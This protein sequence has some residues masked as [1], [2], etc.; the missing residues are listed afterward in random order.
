M[1]TILRL[2]QPL[3]QRPTLFLDS[4]RVLRNIARMSARAAAAGVLLRPHFKTHQSVAVGDW[5]RDYG[6]TG[7][8][9]SSVSMAEYFAAADWR[10][11]TIAL[12]VNP[13]EIARIGEL[14]GRGC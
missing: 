5:F 7:I 3:V 1:S 8:T 6:V 10:D 4:E 9:A 12:P 2:E 11:I 13:R 14:A